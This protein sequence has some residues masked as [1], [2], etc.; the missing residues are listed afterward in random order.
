MDADF[1][2]EMAVDEITFHPDGRALEPGFFTGHQVE[3]LGLIAF[4]LGVAQVHPEQNLGQSC[5]S[6]PPAPGW[7]ARMAFL[8]SSSSSKRVC[9]WLP[10][11]SG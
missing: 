1:L 11:D 6:V 7:M 9:S 8:E 5:D 2:I 4:P 10:R 3:D